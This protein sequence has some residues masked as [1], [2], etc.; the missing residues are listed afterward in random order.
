M[1]ERHCNMDREV[2]WD[3][4]SHHGQRKMLSLW[5]RIMVRA[6]EK[7]SGGEQGKV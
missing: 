6:Q 5:S 7:S 3:E 2:G 4:P 1:M